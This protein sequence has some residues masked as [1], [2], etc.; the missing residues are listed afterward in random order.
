LPAV[1]IER[2]GDGRDDQ[3]EVVGQQVGAAQVDGAGRQ[4]RGAA[5]A[6]R[7]RAESFDRLLD[8]I[9]GVR[10]DVTV[11]DTPVCAAMSRTV[12]RRLAG[13]GICYT[14]LFHDRQHSRTAC[15]PVE[16]PIH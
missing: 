15:H 4:A 12:T 10:C 16:Q 6:G 7:L 2:F 1:Q 8:Q 3:A 14:F 13:L 9:P 11:M 5:R